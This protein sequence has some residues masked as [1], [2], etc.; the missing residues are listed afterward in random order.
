MKRLAVTT[1]TLALI[2]GS[3]TPL[4]AMAQDEKSSE[5]KQ[6]NTAAIVAGMRAKAR[7]GQN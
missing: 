3:L 1:A 2:A 6:D 5:K 4:P 7:S